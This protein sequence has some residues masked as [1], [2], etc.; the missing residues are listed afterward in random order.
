MR[1][2]TAGKMMASY[3]A[4][5]TTSLADANDVH[6][7]FAIENIYQYAFSDLDYAVAFSFLLSFLTSIG[8]SRMNFT[9]A[10]LCFPR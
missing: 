1:F 8:T 3:N 9:G 2:R 7:F 6:E 10:R 5:E 4:G